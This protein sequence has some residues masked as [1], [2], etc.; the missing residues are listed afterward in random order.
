MSSTGD[1]DLYELLQCSEY[2]C[3]IRIMEN[4][5]NS[6]TFIQGNFHGNV[7]SYECDCPWTFFQSIILLQDQWDFP[8]C[9]IYNVLLQMIFHYLN[10]FL[11]LEFHIIGRE[12]LFM[13]QNI[14]SDFF[15]PLNR[16]L[17]WSIKYNWLNLRLS[18]SSLARNLISANIFAGFLWFVLDRQTRNR[19]SE[20]HLIMGRKLKSEHKRNTVV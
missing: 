7:S 5:Y 15:F 17:K 4:K 12:I 10:I 13:Q 11:Y 6:T 20:L 9:I 8:A 2:V 16:E 1:R 19:N 14:F 3:T 18:G